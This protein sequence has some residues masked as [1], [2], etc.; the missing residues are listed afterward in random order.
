VKRKTVKS[1]DN[2]F[3]PQAVSSNAEQRIFQAILFTFEIENLRKFPLHIHLINEKKLLIF[4]PSN[5]AKQ[6]D[7]HSIYI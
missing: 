5:A 2:R 6:K 1:L 7:S 3:A 4:S